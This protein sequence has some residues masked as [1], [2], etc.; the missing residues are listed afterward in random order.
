MNT[1]AEA[2][3]SGIKVARKWGYEVKGVPDGQ[4][5]IIV[6]AGNFHGRTTTIISFSD[7]PVAHDHYGPYTPGFVTRARTATWQR[8]AGAITDDVVAVLLEPIQGE[9]GRARSR[10]PAT[11]PGSASLHPRAQRAVH[12]RRDPVRARPDRPHA[13]L[14]ARGRRRRRLPARQGARRRHRPG[15]GGRCRSRRAR[16]AA[17]RPARQHVRRQPARLRGRTRGGRAAADRRVPG[18]GHPTR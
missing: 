9:A 16:R 8:C 13:G 15:L 7:D 6:A 3:E 14:R 4:A 5:K 11:W 2:V 1:G 18:A 10:R 12:R 17:A